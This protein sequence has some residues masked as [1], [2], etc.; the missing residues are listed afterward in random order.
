MESAP[1]LRR[2][3]I[4]FLALCWLVADA[5]HGYEK[6]VLE[7][8]QV[9]AAGLD[10]ASAQTVAV[11]DFTDLQ[12]NVTE[13]GRFLAEELSVALASPGTLEVIDRGHLRVLLL[14]AVAALLAAPAPRSQ[15]EEP[16][17]DR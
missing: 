17:A 1:H 3:S 8:A 13:L 4:L 11:S 7:V 6:Q 5:S 9:V 2:V 15:A 16:V 10:P 14:F 12:G